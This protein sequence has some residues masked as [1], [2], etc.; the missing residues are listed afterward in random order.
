MLRLLVSGLDSISSLPFGLRRLFLRRQ[1]VGHVALIRSTAFSCH[2]MVLIPSRGIIF[3]HL[4][5]I[6]VVFQPL[7]PLLPGPFFGCCLVLCHN[8]FQWP[9][10]L[11]L[12]GFIGLVQRNLRFIKGSDTLIPGNFRRSSRTASNC[13]RLSCHVCKCVTPGEPLV[14]RRSLWRGISNGRKAII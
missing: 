3:F 7:F 2:G 1:I 12:R 11:L 13:F 9:F 10:A 6:L 5:H 4:Y 8:S 14:P